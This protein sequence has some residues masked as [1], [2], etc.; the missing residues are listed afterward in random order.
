[1]FIKKRRKRIV[2]RKTQKTDQD[3]EVRSRMSNEKVLLQEPGF[4]GLFP[5]GYI[6]SELYN[7]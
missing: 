4:V 7:M 6:V 3:R 5:E 2:K 1:M